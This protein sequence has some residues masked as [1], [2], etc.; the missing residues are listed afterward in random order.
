MSF[1]DE[2]LSGVVGASN[3]SA[4]LAQPEAELRELLDLLNKLTPAWRAVLLSPELAAALDQTQKVLAQAR[5]T[6]GAVEPV[7]V[8]Y[9]VKL[10][11]P[12]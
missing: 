8:D 3:L 6:L 11:A 2:I 1:L 7:L 12:K 9:G 10:E 4:K 5:K